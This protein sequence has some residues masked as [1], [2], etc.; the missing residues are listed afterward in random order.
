MPN[1]FNSGLTIPSPVCSVGEELKGLL[2]IT[3]PLLKEIFSKFSRPH[4]GETSGFSERQQTQSYLQITM[5]LLIITKINEIQLF[6][7]NS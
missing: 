4:Y 3:Q 5:A 6:F 2:K 7:R 1:I